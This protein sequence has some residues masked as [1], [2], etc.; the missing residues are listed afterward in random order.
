MLKYHRSSESAYSAFELSFGTQDVLYKDLLKG[1]DIQPSVEPPAAS[2]F[3]YC[4]F[5]RSQC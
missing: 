3:Q 4:L 2:S 1:A 5:A